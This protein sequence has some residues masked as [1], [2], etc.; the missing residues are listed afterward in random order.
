[1]K[2]IIVLI[3]A[4]IIIVGGG[5]YLSQKNQKNNSKNIK[6]SAKNAKKVKSIVVGDE[7]SEKGRIKDINKSETDSRPDESEKQA[8]K[9]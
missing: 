1:M 5:H 8:K 2:Q 3:I 6:D 9:G 4:G 7:S